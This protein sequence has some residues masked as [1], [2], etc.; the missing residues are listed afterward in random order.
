MVVNTGLFVTDDLNNVVDPVANATFVLLTTDG[1]LYVFNGSGYDQI[2]GGGAGSGI[3]QLT[4]DVTAGPGSGSQAATLAASGVSAGSYTST[5]L[6]V[7]AKGRIT[8]A[9]NGSGGGGGGLT[10]VEHKTITSNSTTVTFSGLDG[11]SDAEYL[12]LGKIKNNSSSGTFD[13]FTIQPNAGA[14]NQVSAQNFLSATSTL[15]GGARTDLPVAFANNAGKFASFNC[16]IHARI[17]VNAVTLP[18]SYE[19]MGGTVDG[20]TKYTFWMSGQDTTGVNMTTMD[21]VGSA[22]NALGDGS[23]LWLYKYEQ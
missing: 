16:H 23:E 22:A 8:A 20:G 17:T 3:T 6:T 18:I 4:G 1:Q 13:Y 9:A 10:L 15:S 7:D 12:L 5:N 19:C 11:N 14:A 21:F 2:S